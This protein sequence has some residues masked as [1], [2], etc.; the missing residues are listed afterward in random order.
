MMG[1]DGNAE[2]GVRVRHVMV[3][4]PISVAPSAPLMDVVQLM[5]RRQI[6]AVLVSDNGRLN[7]IF[8]ERD[9]LR[10]AAEA[11]HGWRQRPVSDWMTRELHTISADASWEEA[12]TLMERIHVR[13]LPVVD[14][15][16]VVGLVTARNLIAWRTEHLN[17]AV[18]ERTSELQRLA[19]QLLL[20]DRQSQRDMAVAGRLLNRLLL[21]KAPPSWPGWSW[22]VH[23]RPLDPLGGD[24]YDFATPDDDHLGVLIADASGHSLPAAMVAIMARIAFAEV[25]GSP[26]P[27]EVLA[28]MNRRLQGLADERFVTAFYGV[29]DRQSRRLTFANAGHPQP[30]HYSAANKTCRPLA[31]SGFML[32][33]LANATYEEQSVDLAPGDR[34]VFYT[35]GAIESRNE[36][37]QAFGIDRLE[38]TAIAHADRSAEVLRDA[39]VDAVVAFRGQAPKAD[40]CTIVVAACQ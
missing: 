17:R 33:I 16:R 38:A 25:L 24:Y 14:Q 1:Q 11:P 28:A 15:E 31:A 40:D 19:E 6:G 32:G 13:H 4:D 3:R 12:V 39:L 21:P 34:L 37:G 22:S 30:L 29:F 9:L 2:S 27:A 35:D 26:R 18:D 5:S 20:R 10:Y 7:G 36:A 8:T 23:F